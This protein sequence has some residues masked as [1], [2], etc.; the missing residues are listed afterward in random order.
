MTPLRRGAPGKRRPGCAIRGDPGPSGSTHGSPRT[1]TTGTGRLYMAAT[2]LDRFH[3]LPSPFGNTCSW[4]AIKITQVK[5]IGWL[6]KPHRG[7][8]EERK[9]VFKHTFLAAAETELPQGLLQ[10]SKL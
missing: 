1:T 6:I 10:P 5:I 8:G 2:A 4:Q 3:T 7:L 9:R